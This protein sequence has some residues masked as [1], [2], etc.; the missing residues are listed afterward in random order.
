MTII[1]PNRLVL[2]IIIKNVRA[3]LVQPCDIKMI[4]RE[5]VLEWMSQTVNEIE[6]HRRVSHRDYST[7][8]TVVITVVVRAFEGS[9]PVC[10]MFQRC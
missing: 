7:V 4:F 2:L 3:I 1:L 10:E 8:L 9:R 6:Y 5:P